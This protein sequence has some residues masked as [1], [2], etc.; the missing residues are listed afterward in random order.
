MRAFSQAF[1]GPARD[2]ARV[3]IIAGYGR[4]PVHERPDGPGVNARALVAGAGGED[5][6]SVL[7]PAPALEGGY[8]GPRPVLQYHELLEEI[9]LE[10]DDTAR[11][12]ARPER[13]RLAAVGE[14]ALLDRERALAEREADPGG[15]SEERTRR[16]EDEAPQRVGVALIA[17]GRA[18]LV[19]HEHVGPHVARHVNAQPESL[20]KQDRRGR[21]LEADE[22]RA[23]KRRLFLGAVRNE[24]CLVGT[25]D[26]KILQVEA[27]LLEVP[28][29][30]PSGWVD[31]N[32]PDGPIQFLK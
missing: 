16:L 17:R 21:A 11:V 12:G 14:D 3:R 26:R 9:G 24:T 2:D 7:P 1:Y 30:M 25:L 27:A 6:P 5:V 28:Y 32:E 20:G 15:L 8:L 4:F 23:G 13:S 19:A 31:P 22:R 29:G 18:L 10:A